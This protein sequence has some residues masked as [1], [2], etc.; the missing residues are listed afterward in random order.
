MSKKRYIDIEIDK[1]T[2]SI[3]N[4]RTGDSFETEVVRMSKVD[5]KKLKKNEWLFDWSKEEV[6]PRR[7]V[8]KL[9]I[10]D[11]NKVIQGLFSLSV[12][13]GY[14]FVHLV[15]SAKFNRGKD[16]VYYGV[17]GNMFAF[18]CMRSRDMGFG[19]FI[20][21]IAKTALIEH[22]AE[23]LKASVIKGQRMMIDED[24]ASELIMKYFK[25]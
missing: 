6:V 25:K 4:V 1:L 16:R 21:F 3:E 5:I 8:Y 11:N 17:A 7:E 22:Y 18:S 23:T 2:N 9:T 10:K 13:V 14:V 20:S 12:E 24:V 15:E 19:G